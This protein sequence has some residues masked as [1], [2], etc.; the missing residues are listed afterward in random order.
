MTLGLGIAA[1]PG[2]AGAGE[3]SAAVVL[4]LQAATSVDI[5]PLKRVAVA[6]RMTDIQP[7]GSEPGLVLRAYERLYSFGFSRSGVIELVTPAAGAP[8]TER[9]HEPLVR[10][11]IDMRR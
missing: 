3:P 8:G 9:W 7:A 1:H 4:R 11:L 2:E 6:A 10:N 5:D